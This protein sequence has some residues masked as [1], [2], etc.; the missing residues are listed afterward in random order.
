M[1]LN[2]SSDHHWFYDPG[3]VRQKLYVPQFPI[4]EQDDNIYL[5]ELSQEISVNTHHVCQPGPGTWQMPISV[6]D[7]I[8]VIILLDM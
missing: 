4:Y 1:C 5:T 3:Q 2:P 7:V 8:D 6:F